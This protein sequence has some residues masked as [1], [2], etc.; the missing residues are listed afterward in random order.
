MHL[1]KYLLAALPALAL[2]QESA[3]ASS[4]PSSTV[5]QTSVITMTKTIVLQRLSTVT[6]TAGVNGTSVGTTSYLT[7]IP[8]GAA[9]PSTAVPSSPRGPTVNAAG[10][11]DATRVALAGLAG[12]LAVAML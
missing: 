9:A 8:S 2:A 7:P 6:A 4:G 1:F 11:L 5:T 10:S 12:M 3:P